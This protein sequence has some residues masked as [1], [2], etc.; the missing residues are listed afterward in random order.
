MSDHKLGWIR[1]GDSTSY[2]PAFGMAP[3]TQATVISMELTKHPREKYGV[4][5]I[6]ADPQHVRENRVLFTVQI[7]G[8]DHASWAY[9]EQIE[10]EGG[11]MH[12]AR[13]ARHVGG[14]I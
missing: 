3:L 10:T 5:V 7:D 14:R 2:R 1:V 11:P 12:L 13:I 8:A 6:E 4:D 9:S